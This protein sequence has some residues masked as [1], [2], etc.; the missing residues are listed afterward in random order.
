MHF[1]DGG[2]G[3]TI[4][5][6]PEGVVEG[7]VR[8]GNCCHQA[9]ETNSTFSQC[10]WGSGIPSSCNPFGSFDITQHDLPTP[11]HSLSNPDYINNPG[12][13]LYGYLGNYDVDMRLRDTI[14][15]EVDKI[16]KI[17]VMLKLECVWADM[18]FPSTEKGHATYYTLL[19]TPFV[20][21]YGY[22]TYMNIGI[23]GAG[24]RWMMRGLSPKVVGCGC[25]PLDCETIMCPQITPDWAI[26]GD[27]HTRSNA[28]GSNPCDYYV[29]DYGI[30]DA[31]IEVIGVDE[32]HLRIR[33]SET[34]PDAHIPGCW[35]AEHGRT[36]DNHAWVPI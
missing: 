24:N 4:P 29:N 9:V 18:P 34:P 26:P 15:G 19:L 36:F 13:N 32:E 11:Q 33:C 28:D 3:C 14:K 20:Q 1:P 10:K 30:G 31:K 25:P 16:I 21:S 6:Q 23:G 5:Y 2:A 35:M 17:G 12:Y 8:G 22:F 27:H 7:V